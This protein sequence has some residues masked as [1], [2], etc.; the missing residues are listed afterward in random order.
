M[1]ESKEPFERKP[2]E[3]LLFYWC[4][5]DSLYECFYPGR[6]VAFPA[7]DGIRAMAMLQVVLGHSAPFILSVFNYSN[8]TKVWGPDGEVALLFSAHFQK[9]NKLII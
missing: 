9:E 8:P 7:L 3:K 5:Q 2:W 1:E 4:L 6:Q